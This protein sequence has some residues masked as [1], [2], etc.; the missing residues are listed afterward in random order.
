MAT[1]NHPITSNASPS[2][3]IIVADAARYWE[4]RRVL[5]NLVL[6][7]VVL[8]W[9]LVSWPHFRPAFNLPS[10]GVLVVLGLIANALY[11]AAYFIDIPLQRSFPAIR[12]K[13]RRAALWWIGMLFALV[14]TNYWIADE[15]YPYVR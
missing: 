9:I 3:R 12:W 5:Y 1:P 4:P 14:L 2:L 15:I 10:F 6:G 8:I 11:C 13:P 7:A